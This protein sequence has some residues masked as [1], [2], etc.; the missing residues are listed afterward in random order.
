MSRLTYL[1][2][3][4]ALCAC[5]DPASDARLTGSNVG[6]LTLQHDDQLRSIFASVELAYDREIAASSHLTTKQPT[7]IIGE[8]G[9]ISGMLDLTG[10]TT[11]ETELSLAFPTLGRFAASG[12]LVYAEATRQIGGAIPVRDAGGALVGKIVLSIQRE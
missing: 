4:T 2:A 11:I 10:E 7:A 5:T 12:V 1:F 8:V 3:A 9:T 6:D